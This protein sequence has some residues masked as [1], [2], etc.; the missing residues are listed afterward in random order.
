MELLAQQTFRIDNRYTL[1][2]GLGSG[3]VS[4]VYAAH[5]DELDRNV[6]IKM[7]RPGMASNARATAR[8]QHE[9]AVLASLESRHVVAV[10]DVG[11]TDEGPWIAMQRLYGHTLQQEVDRY[12]AVEPA[13]LGRLARDILAGV[14][15]VHDRGLVHRDLTPSNIMLDRDD[16]AMVLDL[17]AAT[18]RRCQPTLPDRAGAATVMT[19]DPRS[20]LYQVGLL[21]AYLA[22]GE[23]VH[24]AAATER[25]G[26]R[27]RELAQVI[28]RA[29]EPAERRYACVHEMVDDLRA[30]G[31]IPRTGTVRRAIARSW[32]RLRWS[33]A[34]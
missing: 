29:L 15:A 19:A 5:D 12:G 28:H 10:H 27:S 32:S 7:L 30:I 17:G 33:V 14:A 23:R 8:L 34:T 6:A 26:E 3:A 20:D 18:P 2:H 25:V 13:R 9:G 11:M 4:M 31:T 22:I 1:T 16:V 24:A 21:L